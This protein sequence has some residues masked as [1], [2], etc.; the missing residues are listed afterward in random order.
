MRHFLGAQPCMAPLKT[1]PASRC[2]ALMKCNPHSGLFLAWSI[3]LE[4][5]LLY[6]CRRLLS[7]PCIS[8]PSTQSRALL[9]AV[10]SADRAQ[11][12]R[13]LLPLQRGI[14]CYLT[15][16]VC[17]EIWSTPTVWPI[18]FHETLTS[19]ISTGVREYFSSF[20]FIQSCPGYRLGLF[21]FPWPL[22]GWAGGYCCSCNAPC[23][24]SHWF[25]L[26]LAPQDVSIALSLTL[27][28]CCMHC[29][30]HSLHLFL[31]FSHGAMQ[32]HMSKP[33]EAMTEDD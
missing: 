6:C 13:H 15:T 10:H 31:W 26:H 33:Q 14:H 20:H 4:W 8:P 23:S 3:R 9:S 16:S 30:H 25:M 19:I 21:S 29:T 18:K 7:L 17:R 22:W 24:T 27:S 11:L 28:H 2:L 1:L 5:G 12:H 32:S